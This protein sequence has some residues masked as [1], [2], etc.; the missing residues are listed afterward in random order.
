MAE[1]LDFDEFVLSAPPDGLSLSVSSHIFLAD[2]FD[3]QLDLMGVYDNMGIRVDGAALVASDASDGFLEFL[4]ESICQSPLW[5]SLGL[6]VMCT[7]ITYETNG[8]DEPNIYLEVDHPDK[9]ASLISPPEAVTTSIEGLFCRFDYRTIVRGR[10]HHQPHIHSQQNPERVGENRALGQPQSMPDQSNDSDGDRM[11]TDDM[12]DTRDG[13]D[14]TCCRRRT[15]TAQLTV[16]A[17]YR[18][19]GIKPRFS[20]IQGITPIPPTL[21]DIAPA[22]WNAHYM[23]LTRHHARQLPLIAN[24]IQNAGTWRRTL[25]DKISNLLSEHDGEPPIADDEQDPNRQHNPLHQHLWTLLRSNLMNKINIQSAAKKAHGI[26]GATP[27]DAETRHFSSDAF[28]ISPG[29]EGGEL[30]DYDDDWEQDES[31]IP[32]YW[33]TQ[34]END[35]SDYETTDPKST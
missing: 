8:G 10:R 21:L 4:I 27:G 34:L 15:C 19:I 2:Q 29:D 1:P 14:E 26:L 33:A 24:I 20:G 28:P 16:A 18:M 25:Q 31:Q 35:M 17:L 13:I 3:P 32:A 30:F 12:L 23:E 6:S 5:P 11:Q 22:M 7:E 9:A